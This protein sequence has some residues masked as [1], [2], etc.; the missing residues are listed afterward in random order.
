MEK[1]AMILITGA[2]GFIGSCLLQYMNEQGI[3]NIILVD[4]FTDAVKEK[5]WK[6]KKYKHLVDRELLLEWLDE[7]KPNISFVIHL[8][9]RT[10]I[11]DADHALLQELNTEYSEDIWNYCTAF[12]IPL[13]YA[14]AAATYGNGELGY[15]DDDTMLCDLKPQ[16]AY[17]TSKNEFDK[18][19]VRQLNMPPAWA[20][21]KLFNVYGPNEYHKKHASSEILNAWKR[22][23]KNGSVKLSE[24]DKGELKEGTGQRDFVYVKDVVKVIQ[25][26]FNAMTGHNWTSQK[27]G[28]YNVA[29]GKA[30]SFNDVARAVFAALD[31]QAGITNTEVSPAQGDPY[32][33][34][35]VKL[36][37]AGYN[38]PFTSLEDGVEDYVKNYLTSGKYY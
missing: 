38:A 26:M 12:N 16:N 24:S 7:N 14:S 2:A 23:E 11:A 37:H 18:W 1:P 29:T 20:G 28:I 13:I 21:L 4:K 5:N 36:K 27:N 3:E 30:H 9:A 17:G 32:E 35:I 31:K 22:A 8:G 33:V 6:Q 15:D 10:N 25:W 34:S 19:A